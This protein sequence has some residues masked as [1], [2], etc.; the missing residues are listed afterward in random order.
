MSGWSH[1]GEPDPEYDLRERLRAELEQEILDRYAEID[2]EKVRARVEGKT[3]TFDALV[4]AAVAEIGMPLPDNLV[5]AVVR[6]IDE[7]DAKAGRIANPEALRKRVRRSL[8]RQ[9][10]LD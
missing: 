8:K 10:L 6:I 2:A 7:A 3:E 4:N 9:G 1:Y 5:A